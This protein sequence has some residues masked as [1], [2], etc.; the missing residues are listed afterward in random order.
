MIGLPE[1][2]EAGEYYFKYIDLVP[3]GDIIARLN[4]QME[5]TL[6]FL[7]GITEEKSLYRYEPAKW[8]IREMWNHVND[9]E[10]MFLFRALWFARG[11][12]DPLPSFN[13]DLAAATAKADDYSWASHMEDFQAVRLATLTFFRNLPQDAWMRRGEASGNPFTVRALAFIIAGHTAHHMAVLK[14]KYL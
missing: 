1:R 2:T 10:R 7:Q 9:T 12:D 6:V 4:H 5:E 3:E 14:E 11:F 8:S 13:Q